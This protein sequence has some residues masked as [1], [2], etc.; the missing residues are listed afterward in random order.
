MTNVVRVPVIW[1]TFT[2]AYREPGDAIIA[3]L[4][5]GYRATLDNDYRTLVDSGYVV[6]E[7]G[8]GISY[9]LRRVET[10]YQWE[11]IP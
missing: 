7:P 6:A 10:Y 4:K 9:V 5:Y 2:A 3:A 8:T 1:E 11:R